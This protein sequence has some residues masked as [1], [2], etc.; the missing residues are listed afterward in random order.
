MTCKWIENSGE[1]SNE[2][3]VEQKIV[4]PL[5][6]S[7]MP[8]GL[9]FSAPHIRTK[10]NIKAFEIEKRK[11]RKVYYPDYVIVVSGFPLLI[12]EAKPPTEEL[13]EAYREAR[14]YSTEL[15]SIFPHD[16]NPVQAILCTNGVKIIGGFADADTPSLQLLVTEAEPS[17]PDF[18]NLINTFG[19]SE[20]EKRANELNNIY[21][22]KRFFQAVRELGGRAVRN[23]EVGT[24]SFGNTI[25]LDYQHLFNPTTPDE[26]AYIVQN[27]YIVSKSRSRYIDPIDKIV[28]AAI[29]AS[30]S[31][32]KTIYSKSP[33]PL[34]DKLKF[35]DSKNLEHKILLLVGGVG[36]GKSTFV[37]YLRYKA[38]PESLIESTKWLRV[39]LNDAPLDKELIYG[40]ICDQI[41]FEFTNS[42]DN[43]FDIN[44]LENILDIYSSE[45]NKFRKGRG[46]LLNEDD[47]NRELYNELTRLQSDKIL[48]IK[49]YIRHF[50]AEKGKLA[51]LVLDNCDKRIRDEQLLMFQAAQWIQSTFRC[52]IFLPI[53]DITYDNHRHEPPLDT[54]IKDLVFRI[55]PPGFQE[56][57]LKRIELAFKEM[58]RRSNEKTLS[59]NL[60]STIRVSFPA[61]KLA[62]FLSS[63]LKS[64]F[65]YDRFLRWMIVGLAGNNIRR[66]MEIFLDFC[67][68]GHITEGEILK[69]CQA[70]GKYLIPFHT[71]FRVL[72][73]M[74]RRFYDSESS[75]VKNVFDCNPADP[76]PL[77]FTRLLILKWLYEKHR[78]SGPIAAT[79][80]H[81][82]ST[83][84]ADLYLLG[85]NDEIIDREM[86]YLLKSRCIMAEHLRLDILEDEDLVSLAPTGHVH[87]KLVNTMDYV[88]SIA[89]ELYFDDKAIAKEIASSLSNKEQQYSLLSMACNT[90]IV[91]N[92]LDSKSD[93]IFKSESYLDCISW[94]DL[95]SIDSI[96]ESFRKDIKIESQKD[97]WLSFCLKIKESN[98]AEGTV[99]DVRN[100]GV[101]VR[102][103]GFV[104]L[105][106]ESNL[107]EYKVKD[108][109]I[110]D[111][112]KVEILDIESSNSKRIPLKL[113][114]KLNIHFEKSKHKPKIQKKKK[115]QKKRAQTKENAEST[116]SSEQLTIFSLIEDE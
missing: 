75:Y 27:A 12:I 101:F 14:L 92:Y 19:L 15:N 79:G 42:L 28:R 43:K 107:G 113:L 99:V 65:E 35:V 54:A 72:T 64:L 95:L 7:D 17:S 24:N 45:I 77:Y 9:G 110:N 78:V 25:A 40:W 87:L 6:T 111:R 91:L 83:L 47:F 58:E 20:L 30:E 5:L 16:I 76:N 104:G 61:E 60:S 74:N 86:M 105:A 1:I 62:Y 13:D 55:E 96:I 67:K 36:T 56:V 71:V 49:A 84:K 69:I 59:Y 116:P 29:P 102:M 26:R 90:K 100:Y 115:S 41:L 53:R 4:Y 98:V 68:S 112:V 70:E 8:Y 39:D 10:A 51:I 22:P 3:D 93:G 31:D 52:L 94:K 18:F 37:D 33:K 114:E 63:I 88:S 85:L 11:N 57:L 44:N 103:S 50:C 81:Q 32:S 80:Y 2:S 48:T 73:R 106:H 82:V 23:E 38:L 109:I 21:R 89:E 34:L 46:S 108:F 97:S 66:A